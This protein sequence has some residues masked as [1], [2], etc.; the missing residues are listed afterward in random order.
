MAIAIGDFVGIVKRLGRYGTLGNVGDQPTTDIL[1]SINLRGGRVWA[2]ADWRWSRE[3]LKFAMVPGQSQ[4]VV[5]A[6][7]GNPIDRIINL[8]PIDLTATPPV[9][10]MP[11]V[12]YTERQFYEKCNLRPG[13]S[14]GYPRS[15]YNMG[16]N[17]A[18]QWQITVYPVPTAAFNMSGSAKAVL[19]PYTLAM[20]AAN[21]PITYFPN[22]VV[23]DTLLDGVL[24]DV[25]AI[26]G[27]DTEK[28]RLDIQFEA[29]IKKLIAEQIGVA[30]DNTP[31]T[32]DPPDVI[33]RRG[34][35]RLRWRGPW[36]D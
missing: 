23:L 9:Q 28:A 33:M 6:S 26:Q 11:L 21:A 8:I 20:V 5:L 15:Y 32:S 34:G 14:E 24:S 3:I 35:T 2:A 19:V 1:N 27:N 12:E 30:E 4:Y 17:A 31:P 22:G 25:M 18:G 36:L 16:Q 29:K 13:W 10:G 7:S